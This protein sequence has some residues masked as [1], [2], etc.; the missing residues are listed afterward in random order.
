MILII[1]VNTQIKINL[2][3]KNTTVK[4]IKKGIILAGGKR[5]SCNC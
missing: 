1:I 2:K 3:I 5:N 4:M